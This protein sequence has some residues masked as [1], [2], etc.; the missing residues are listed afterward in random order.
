MISKKL[1]RDRSRYLSKKR[2]KIIGVRKQREEDQETRRLPIGS[3]LLQQGQPSIVVYPSDV[4]APPSR[5]LSPLHQPEQE[6]D[7]NRGIASSSVNEDE[8]DSLQ[9]SQTSTSSYL[10]TPVKKKTKKTADC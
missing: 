4:D 10:P 2:D 8:T 7:V 9:V 6:T 5:P 3:T 1:R